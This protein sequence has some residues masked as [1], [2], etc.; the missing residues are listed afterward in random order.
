M[1]IHTWACVHAVSP[2]A[3]H[4]HVKTKTEET[5]RLHY[6]APELAT[7]GETT[8]ADIYAFGICTLEVRHTTNI[9]EITLVFFGSVLCYYWHDDPYT[10]LTTIYLPDMSL[11]AKLGSP[12][13]L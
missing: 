4:E 2:D 13:Q 5:N 3:I 12:W 11:D 10:S 6:A 7:A 9:I 8:A 1:C